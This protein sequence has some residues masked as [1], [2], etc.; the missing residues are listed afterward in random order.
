MRRVLPLALVAAALAVVAPPA[1]A[2]PGTCTIFWKGTTSTAWET[3]TNWSLTDGGPN[4]GRLPNATDVVCKSTAPTR[5][6]V[7][8]ATAR[9]VAGMNFGTGSLTLAGGNLTV[10]SVANGA[11]DSTIRNIASSGFQLGGTAAVT[12]TGPGDP[13]TPV[14]LV[15]AGA[16]PVAVGSGSALSY[17]ALNVTNGKTLT[18]NGTMTPA[19]ASV[20]LNLGAKLDNFGTITIPPSCGGVTPFLSDGNVNTTLTNEPTG[21]LNLNGTSFVDVSGIEWHNNGTV[22][23]AVTDLYFHPTAADTG[24]YNLA[25]GTTLHQYGPVTISPGTVTGA[26]TWQSRRRPD[27]HRQRRLGA[28]PVG[29]QRD[30]DRV[31]RRRPT[32]RSPV[33]RSTG[34]APSRFR[35]AATPR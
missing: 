29:A 12:L 23:G 35:P 20:S 6:D 8:I 15:L 17:S 10:G 14:N 9:T 31:A 26:G 28:P 2:A 5:T 27:H 11:F 18:N 1:Q 33:P 4:A 13:V 32:R 19:C 25:A 30:R 21:V 3:A 34:P 22:N 7:V 16:G 24:T